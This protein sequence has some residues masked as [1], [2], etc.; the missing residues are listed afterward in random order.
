LD[1]ALA[2]LRALD[3]SA[4]EAP[5]PRPYFEN[6]ELDPSPSP[7]T[8]PLVLVPPEV[9]ELEGLSSE[10]EESD[11]QVRKEEWPEYFLRLFPDD[12]SFVVPICLHNDVVER[13]Q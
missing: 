4:F 3:A 11:A 9:I 6:P 1:N 7:F 12:V 2:V 8:L 13:F 10:E 5:C